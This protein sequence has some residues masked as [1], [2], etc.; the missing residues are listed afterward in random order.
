MFTNK[1][2]F[3]LQ[4]SRLLSLAVLQATAACKLSCKLHTA[5]LWILR[6]T[7]SSFP[8][9]VSISVLGKWN[10]IRAWNSGPKASTPLFSHLWNISYFEYLYWPYH[11]CAII[12]LK[13]FNFIYRDIPLLLSTWELRG[14]LKNCGWLNFR[15]HAWPRNQASPHP[16]ARQEGRAARVPQRYAAE[17]GW[18]S[19]SS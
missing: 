10:E 1:N 9:T 12:S 3:F 14:G 18:H 11:S 7:S 13:T 17:W 19:D 6:F 2:E 16:A 4:F 5:N 15:I 8:L